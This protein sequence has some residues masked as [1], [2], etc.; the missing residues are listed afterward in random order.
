MIKNVKKVKIELP[1]LY[2]KESCVK[3]FFTEY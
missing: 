1:N 3:N 2:A